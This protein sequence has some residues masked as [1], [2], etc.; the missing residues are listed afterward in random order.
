MSADTPFRDIS[1]P[2]T[3]PHPSGPQ[4]PDRNAPH[5]PATDEHPLLAAH[6]GILTV[7][8]LGTVAYRPTWELQDELAEQR[9]GRRIGDRLL[10]LEH[11]PV[12]TIGRGGDEANLLATPD[13]L[14]E[15]GAELI[16]IDRGGDITYHGPGQIVAYPIVEL[17]DP[18][19]L[20][21]Y[22]RIL[23]AAIIDTARAFGVASARL[24]G[25][26]GIWIDGERKL[27]AI[28]VR[29]RRG[30]TTHGLA[31]NVNTD[32]KWFDEMIPCGIPDKGVTSLARE[33]GKPLPMEAVEDE[34]ACQLAG[35]LGL[36]LSDGAEGVI[37]P[38]GAREQ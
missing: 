27:A 24:E 26:P 11:F 12:Y 9:R 5:R 13:R 19:D 6:G 10:L 18:L 34:L 7:E 38:A 30:V 35:H 21:R 4:R 31:L 1:A 33:L 28:G 32:L 36:R 20:R 23:E 2:E 16:R 15:I 8:H 14:R 29:V 17:R 3:Q 22:V 25:Q 37:G